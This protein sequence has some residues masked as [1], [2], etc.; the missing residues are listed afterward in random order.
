MYS[1]KQPSRSDAERK[2]LKNDVRI[3]SHLFIATQ[4]R[5][6]DLD[7]FFSHE[8][9]ANPPSLACDGKIRPGVKADLLHC[10]K[11]ASTTDSFLATNTSEAQSICN[12]DSSDTGTAEPD[13]DQVIMIVPEKVDGKVLEGSVLVNFLKPAKQSTFAEYA[14]T[15]FVP[16]VIKELETVERVDIVFDTYR[17]ESLKATTR[18]KRGIGIRRK[19]KEQSQVPTN[20]HSFLRIDRNKTELFRFLSEKIITSIE[21]NKIVVTAF[22]DK[23]L[24]SKGAMVEN[25]SPCNHEEADT[26]VFLHALDMRRHNSIEHVMIKT[27]DTD[28]V[29]LAV[30]LFAELNIKELWIDF[31]SGQNQAYYPIHTIYNSLGPEKSK[32]LLFFHAFTGCD[33]TSFFANCRKK[34]AWSTWFNF[35][36]VTETFIKLSS[37]PTITT[38]KEAMPM[39]ERFVVLMYDRSSNCIDVNSCRRNLFVKKGRGMEALPPTFAALLQHSY[40]AAYQAGYVWRQSLVGQQQLPPPEDWGWKI[41]EG[42][43]LP[44][45]TDLPEAAIAVRELIKCG[46]NSEKGCLGRCKCV[47]AE[48]KC[49]ELCRCNGNCERD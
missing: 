41:V 13:N 6:G 14:R 11:K 20:W 9:S 42:T 26:R 45:W 17:K 28:V 25:L 4:T 38:V 46:F 43:Y 37:K 21:T 22:E 23:A 29:V 39:L 24:I 1:R 44:H 19:V 7:T 35:D 32:G 3:F 48:L 2:S 34:S 5:N 40:R 31:G 36:G 12:A 10:L 18:Q 8:N 30:A 15:V 49:T 16:K 47:R 33:Q 27:V